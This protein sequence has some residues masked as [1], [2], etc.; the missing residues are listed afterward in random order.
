MSEEVPDT[1]TKAV[2]E[3]I[4]LHFVMITISKGT[5]LPAA[6]IGGK[7]DPYCLV[8]ANG[9]TF[10]TKVIQKT[11]NPEWNE[12]TTFC[13]L[14]PCEE[15]LFEL[16]DEDDRSKDDVLGE[17]RLPIDS[18]YADGAA[19]FSGDLDVMT[20][21][22]K[23]HGTVTVSVKCRVLRPTDLED[24]I[25]ELTTVTDGL[26]VTVDEQHT[27]LDALRTEKRG[28]E[29]KSAELSET[30]AGVEG[31]IAI[32]QDEIEDHRATIEDCTKQIASAD[33]EAKKATAEKAELEKAKTDADAEL[34]RLKDEEVAWKLEA[35][36]VELAKTVKEL[37]TEIAAFA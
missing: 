15:L 27:R 30:K 20:K 6:D 13:F 33:D 28:L 37:K 7:S 25:A 35:E 17:A 19:G 2:S 11:L 3:D 5:G 9:Q 18:F 22:G 36:K 34:K 4:V 10:R 16:W 1:Q 14:D 32:L 31:G 29:E 12:K 8:T 26:Q 21:K 23:A 24:R